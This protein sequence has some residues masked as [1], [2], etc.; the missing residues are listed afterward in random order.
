MFYTRNAELDYQ[1]IVPTNQNYTYE[2]LKKNIEK[3]KIAYPFLEIGSI[4]QSVLKKDLPY[5]RIGYG[6]KQVMYNG[7]N[8]CK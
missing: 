4:G 8:A 6:Q 7:R 5:I 3:L 1:N 2:I